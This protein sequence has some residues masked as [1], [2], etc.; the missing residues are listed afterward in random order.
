[1]VCGDGWSHSS[2]NVA[3]RQLGYGG[4]ESHGT[5]PNTSWT[6]SESTWYWVQSIQCDGSEDSL[7]DCS[8]SVLGSYSE[9][10][11]N[12]IASVTCSGTERQ[13]F[14]NFYVHKTKCKINYEKA[15]CY[16]YYN[17]Y[18][19]FT[20]GAS[21][22]LVGGASPAEGILQIFIE[23]FWGTVCRRGWGRKSADVACRLLG[24]TRSIET[25]DSFKYLSSEIGSSPIWLDDV[26]CNGDERS[27]LDCPH[28]PIGT[29]ACGHSTDIGLMCTS[30]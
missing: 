21:L 23:G 26:K 18:F 20:V 17:Y 2:A 30:K 1:M 11:S 4:V 24:Y 16:Y 10:T 5:E 19:Y 29:H 12:T 15:K 8:V 22:R 14:I 3:C 13:F 6:G 28:G 9:C 7:A 27:L 25:V